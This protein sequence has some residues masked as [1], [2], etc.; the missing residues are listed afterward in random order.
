MRKVISLVLGL[1]LLGA[2]SVSA[3]AQTSKAPK[4]ATT[5]TVKPKVVVVTAHKLSG[6][7]K[8]DAKGTSFVLGAK[9]GPYNVD[10]KGA[11]CTNK[12]KFTSVGS[13]K[14]GDGVTVTGTVNGK[15]VKATEVKVTSLK[16]AKSSSA[17]ATSIKPTTPT[18]KK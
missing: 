13:L 8:G 18:K 15:N 12:G 2:L 17:K 7:V 9:G 16:S 1:S 3:V 4:H 6:F 11:K 14:G 5:S 10:A